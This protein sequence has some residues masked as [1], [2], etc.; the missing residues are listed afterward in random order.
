MTASIDCQTNPW[1]CEFLLKEGR[2]RELGLYQYVD[3]TLDRRFVKSYVLF[4]R[5]SKLEYELEM[6]NWS[7]SAK[8]RLIEEYYGVH[9]FYNGYQGSA[10]GGY[11]QNTPLR[12]KNFQNTPPP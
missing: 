10:R 12:S 2:V 7:V 3:E 4:Q 11:S 5:D 9:K 6:I 8:P 1:I